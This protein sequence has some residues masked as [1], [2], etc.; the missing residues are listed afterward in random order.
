MHRV[1]CKYGILHNGLEHLWILVLVGVLEQMELL[2]IRSWNFKK[3]RGEGKERK[4]LSY[5]A[6]TVCLVFSTLVS[7]RILPCIR[8][9]IRL[10]KEERK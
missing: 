10:G 3:A 7:Q 4:P 1:I 9:H 5:G 6:L 2:V 8:Y